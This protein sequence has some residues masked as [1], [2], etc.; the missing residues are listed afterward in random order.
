MS[1]LFLCY[2]NTVVTRHIN[3]KDMFVVIRECMFSVKIGSLVKT[4]CSHIIEIG[5]LHL[6]KKCVLEQETFTPQ[7]YW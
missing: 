2:E 5:P 6:G 1:H 7:K 4:A 3:Q